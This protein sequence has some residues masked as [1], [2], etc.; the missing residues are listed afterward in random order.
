LYA[1]NAGDN[2]MVGTR[3]DLAP[4]L[5]QSGGEF[6]LRYQLTDISH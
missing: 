5:D 3:L 2:D 1:I 4:Q 6:P